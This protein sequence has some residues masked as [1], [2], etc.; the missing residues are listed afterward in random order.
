MIIITDRLCETK[1]EKRTRFSDKKCPGLLLDRTPAGSSTFWFRYTDKLTGQRERVEIGTYH[2]EAFR[3]EHARARAYAVKGQL[4]RGE[5]VAQRARQERQAAS[6]VRTIL[7][8]VDERIEWM[9][10]PER[11]VD[12]QMRARIETWRNVASQLDRF[13]L[14]RLGR[15]LATEVT[16]RDIAAISDAIMAGDYGVPSVANARH[17]RRAA[18]AMFRWAAQPPREYIKTSPC[19][20]LPK[21]PTEHPRTRV[22]KAHE[23]KTL[24]NGLGDSKAHLAIKFALA[25]MLRSSEMRSLRRDEIID[26]DGEFPVMI[27]PAH[28]VKKRR[29]IIQPLSPL[30][31]SIIKQAMQDGDEYVFQ[32]DLAVGPI[33]RHAMAVVL[34]GRQ[35]KEQEGLCARLGI[36]PCTPHDLRRTA[37]TLAGEFEDL[38]DS[39]IAACLDHQGTGMTAAPVVTG[40]YNRSPKLRQKAKVLNRVAEELQRIV[41]DPPALRAVA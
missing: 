37:A 28:R 41:S 27:I 33:H 40:T 25:S 11:K 3:T 20:D 1:V 7:E 29:N 35:D 26:L 13:V 12:G 5:N 32:S 6:Q 31:V 8:I 38:A 9:R 36:E 30:A 4:A 10:T 14:P 23:I 17:F 24:W 34:R 21:L 39:W 22:L 19:T 18:S 15:M 16:R 2:P